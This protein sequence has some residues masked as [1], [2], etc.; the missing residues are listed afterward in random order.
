MQPTHVCN[1]KQ[2]PTRLQTKKSQTYVLVNSKV[3]ASSKAC[4]EAMSAVPAKVIQEVT[5]AMASNKGINQ[6]LEQVIQCLEANSLAYRMTILPKQLLTHPDNRGRTMISFHDVWQKGNAMLAVGIQK[7]LLQDAMC[8]E[9]SK[10]ETKRQ[11]QVEKNQQLVQE[12]NGHL[13]PLTGEER[14]LAFIFSKPH[15]CNF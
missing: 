14:F 9:F 7:G 4:L 15:Q 10:N 13:A 1:K 5:D 8:S 6:Q 2:M 12:A 3:V 11:M